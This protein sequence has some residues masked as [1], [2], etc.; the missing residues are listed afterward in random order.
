ML[1]WW[2]IT[3]LE[4]N[5]SAEATIYSENTPFKLQKTDNEMRK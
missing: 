2:A 4:T 5:T 3:I 1:G